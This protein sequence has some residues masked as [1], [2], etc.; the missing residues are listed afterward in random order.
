[1]ARFTRKIMIYVFILTPGRRTGEILVEQTDGKSDQSNPRCACAP[2]VND[3]RQCRLHCHTNIHALK[4]A[5]VTLTLVPVVCDKGSNRL[6]ISI[7]INE[8]NQASP[9]CSHFMFAV[10]SSKGGHKVILSNLRILIFLIL[11]DN[12]HYFNFTFSDPEQVVH[13][14]AEC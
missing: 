9:E 11:I 2:R 13:D 1:M 10:Y 7:N 12:V 4:Q 6:V 8:Y 5:Q 14:F 3:R